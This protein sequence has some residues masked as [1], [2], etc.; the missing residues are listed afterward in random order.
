MSSDFQHFQEILMRVQQCIQL[1]GRRCKHGQ[2][3][4]ECLDDC[5]EC[6]EEA[7]DVFGSEKRDDGWTDGFECGEAG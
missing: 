7:L 1:G 4:C 5:H 3:I 2:L 6:F